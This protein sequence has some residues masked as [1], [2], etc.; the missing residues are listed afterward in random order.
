MTCDNYSH[1]SV[2]HFPFYSTPCLPHVGRLHVDHTFIGVKNGRAYQHAEKKKFWLHDRFIPISC[3]L[4]S[5]AFT[6]RSVS[7]LQDK[8]ETEN[9]RRPNILTNCVPSRTR[10]DLTAGSGRL[11][12][13]RRKVSQ[14]P[15][16]CF[17][18]LLSIP[19]RGTSTRMLRQTLVNNYCHRRGK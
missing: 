6:A 7:T 3:A 12:G 15:E 18:V 4:F 5:H 10:G 11:S 13:M 9:G 16:T 1:E 14:T 17:T 19:R 8:C 2:T